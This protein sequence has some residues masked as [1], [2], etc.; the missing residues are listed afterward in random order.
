MEKEEHPP[1]DPIAP[2]PTFPPHLNENMLKLSACTVDSAI[3]NE[4]PARVPS[5]SSLQN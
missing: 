4:N 2:Q 3:Y 1:S 5:L